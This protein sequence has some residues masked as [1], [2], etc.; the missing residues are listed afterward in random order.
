MEISFLLV[1]KSTSKKH[2]Q[3]YNHDDT[4]YLVSISG[5]TVAS[6]SLDSTCQ[7]WSISTKEKLYSIK[8]SRAITQ[9]RLLLD[10]NLDFDLITCSDD[11]TVKLWYQGKIFKILEHSVPC[12]SFDLDEERR[13]IAVATYGLTR[14]GCV[15]LWRLDRYEKI[16]EEKIDNVAVVRFNKNATKIIAASRFGHIYGILL[17]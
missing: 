16:L 2:F 11:K 15:A 4:A 10:Q 13:M 3:N 1:T 6:G 9:V 5:D 8:H 7:V 17:E 14:P 12:Y